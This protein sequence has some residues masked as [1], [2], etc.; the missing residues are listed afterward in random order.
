MAREATITQEQVNAAADTI[1]ATGT[2]P[3]SRAVR[4]ALGGGSMAT[5]LRLLQVWQG[6]QTRQPETPVVLPAGLQR[7][8]VDFI[9]QEVAAAKTDLQADIVA[10]QQVTAD[11]IAENERQAVMIEHQAQ[12]LEVIQSEKAEQ[13]GTIAQL[14][15]ELT[16]TESYLRNERLAAENARIELAKA[17]LRLGAVPKL[18]AEGERL[19]AE[20]DRE[21]CARV[22]AEQVAAVAA[23]KLEAAEAKAA[24]LQTRLAQI[25]AQSGQVTQERQTLRVQVQAQQTALDTCAREVQQAKQQTVEARAAAKAAGE[26][27]AELR[28]QLQAGQPKPEAKAA[29]KRKTATPPR[30]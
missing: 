20:L 21:H 3:T 27:A 1:R 17:Q 22:T 12:A 7:A 4:E 13:G 11:L 19:R 10:A 18:E 14:E 2:K 23:A 6:G 24:D 5:V 15:A 16:R 9:G 26:E 8:L 28:G 25:E 30:P 29:T